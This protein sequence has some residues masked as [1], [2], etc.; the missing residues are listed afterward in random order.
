MSLNLEESWEINAKKLEKKFKKYKKNPYYK[1]ELEQ[2]S[3]TIKIKWSNKIIAESNECIILHEEAHSQVYYF[4]P[5]SIKEKY[6]FRT[7]LATHCHYKGNAA[8]WTLSFK[9]TLA[10]NAVWAY[11]YP[12][13]NLL[14][15]KDYYAFYSEGMG[16]NF[17]ITI[18]Y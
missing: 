2:I 13:K 5:I 15:I 8:Y 17:G 12:Y 9:D 4:P 7:D 10:E 14:K 6:F 3:K 16:K 18:I 11:P 1:I